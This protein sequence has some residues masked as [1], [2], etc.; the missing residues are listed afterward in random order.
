MNHRSPFATHTMEPFDLNHALSTNNNMMLSSSFLLQK[1]RDNLVKYMLSAS[2]ELGPQEESICTIDRTV[3]VSCQLGNVHKR[4]QED[5]CAHHI[6]GE[7]VVLGVFDG[8]GG[9]EVADMCKKKFSKHIAKFINEHGWGAIDRF[10]TK[11]CHDV[12]RHHELSKVGSTATLVM[13]HTGEKRIKCCWVGDSLAAVVRKDALTGALSI[14]KITEPHCMI[15]NEKE[16]VRLSQLENNKYNISDRIGGIVNMTRAV[17][18]EYLRDCGMLSELDE[19]TLVIEDDMQVLIVATDGVW[20]FVSDIIILR[21][22]ERC[23]A[24]GSSRRHALKSAQRFIV[25]MAVE[26]GND[27]VTMMMVDLLSS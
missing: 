8:H 27:N 14:D 20:N 10:F 17:G 6:Q 5:R 1:S 26:R 22:L 18:D 19:K 11:L 15:T 12:E 24:K 13:T 16:R 21:A 25:K 3:Y 7:F 4:R 9:D 23:M 2:V